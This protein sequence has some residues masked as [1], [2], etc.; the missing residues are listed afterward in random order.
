MGRTV[1]ISKKVLE[2]ILARAIAAADMPLPE[3]DLQVED[4]EM[5][6]DDLPPPPTLVRSKVIEPAG[7]SLPASG[8]HPIC[9]RVP[10]RVIRAFQAQAADTGTSYQTLMNRALNAAA[11][12]Y[13]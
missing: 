4:I 5:S 11:A 3:L 12:G 1:K 7:K 10:A 2:A 13:V 9:I 6:L 8:T